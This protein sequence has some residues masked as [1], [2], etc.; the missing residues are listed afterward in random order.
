MGS[1][2]EILASVHLPL[3]ESGSTRALFRAGNFNFQR[4][5]GNSNLLA[6][7][8]LIKSLMNLV[9]KKIENKTK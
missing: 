9:K 5:L 8:I 4:I 3:H 2:G 6:L 1:N 7:K